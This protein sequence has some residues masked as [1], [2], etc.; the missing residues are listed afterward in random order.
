MRLK[1]ACERA[2]RI[3]ESSPEVG[4]KLD[5]LIGDY[6]FCSTITRGQLDKLNLHRC[7]NLAERVLKEASVKKGDIDE[8]IVVVEASD[9]PTRSHIDMLKEFFAGT[10][11]R[12]LVKSEGLAYDSS[13]PDTLSLRKLE[14][15]LL[16][17]GCEFYGGIVANIINVAVV[18]EGVHRDSIALHE[19]SSGRFAKF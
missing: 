2:K 10:S 18:P 11:G 14:M 3:L 9:I 17:V 16:V 6:D 1:A 15:G 13:G 7:L 8:V 4:I 12:E 19:L 5:M